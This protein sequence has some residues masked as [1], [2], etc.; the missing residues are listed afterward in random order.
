MHPFSPLPPANDNARTRSSPL[1]A[2]SS[3]GPVT[4][5]EVVAEST[6]PARLR[7]ALAPQ[8]ARP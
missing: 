2:P 8:E 3:R 7:L 4:S 5:A 1:L 6:P